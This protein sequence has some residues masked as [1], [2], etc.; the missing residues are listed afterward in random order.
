MSELD[1]QAQPDVPG[2][3]GAAAPPVHSIVR[4]G[5]GVPD[6][7]VLL[8]LGG[9]LDLAAAPELRRHL[10]EPAQGGAHR[11]VLDLAEVQFMDSSML[12]ELLRANHELR[13]AGATLVLAA[14]QPAVRRLFELTRTAELFEVA[15][16]RG[17]ALSG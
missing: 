14:P 5:G 3:R 11:V 1:P 12:K 6:G 8:V 9:E 2:D 7:C 17:A 13:E 10:E 16:D 4:E 15:D